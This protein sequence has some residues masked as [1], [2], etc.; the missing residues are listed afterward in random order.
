VFV[1]EMMR[2]EK[3][4]SGTSLG[5]SLVILFKDKSQNIFGLYLQKQ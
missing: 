3:G 5:T 2:Q 1:G 4:A